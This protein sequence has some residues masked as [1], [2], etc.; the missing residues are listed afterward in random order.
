MAT[1]GTFVAGGCP[2]IALPARGKTVPRITTRDGAKKNG[3]LFSEGRREDGRKTISADPLT[4]ARCGNSKSSHKKDRRKGRTKMK[5]VGEE[6]KAFKRK[7]EQN[8]E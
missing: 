2:E 4:K 1:G 3:V 6:R 7:R 8:E 5:P